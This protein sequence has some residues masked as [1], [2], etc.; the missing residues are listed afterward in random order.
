VLAVGVAVLGVIIF[1]RKL[2]A[3]QVPEH[4]SP[5]VLTRINNRIPGTPPVAGTG[6]DCGVISSRCPAVDRGRTESFRTAGAVGRLSAQMFL[7]GVT[8]AFSQACRYRHVATV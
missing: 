1:A 2:R 8:R 3:S 4:L 5:Q 6:G 7:W